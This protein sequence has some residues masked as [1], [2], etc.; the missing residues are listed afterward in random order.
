MYAPHYSLTDYGY[1]FS[2]GLSIYK[3][4]FNPSSEIDIKLANK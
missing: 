3:Q 4:F 2:S 1:F